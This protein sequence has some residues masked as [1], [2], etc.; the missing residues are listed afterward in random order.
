MVFNKKIYIYMICPLFCLHDETPNPRS[1]QYRG[2]IEMC[3]LTSERGDGYNI[4]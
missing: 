3:F 1:A 2:P 4:S